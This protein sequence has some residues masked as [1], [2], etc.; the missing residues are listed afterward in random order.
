MVKDVDIVP[1]IKTDHFAISLHVKYLENVSRDPGF[2][3]MNQSLLKDNA[4]VE[5]MQEKLATWKEE[6][7]MNFRIRE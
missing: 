4:F 6:G 1:S 7:N 2:W 5:T 3:K